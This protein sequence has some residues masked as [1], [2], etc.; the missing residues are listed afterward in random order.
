[1]LKI[2]W[3]ILSGVLLG[4]VGLVV[5]QSSATVSV[6]ATASHPIPSTLCGSL[7]FIYSFRGADLQYR[8]LYVRG[9]SLD[10][11]SSFF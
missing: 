2:G 1:M 6:S 3:S 7:K 5:A 11:A 4:L 10:H 9:K 8:G